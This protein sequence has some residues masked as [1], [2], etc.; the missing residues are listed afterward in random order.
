VKPKDFEQAVLELAMTT[1]VPLTRA[2]IVF[3]SGV[4]AKQTD[5]WLDEMVGNGLLEFDSDDAG[6]MIYKVCGAQRPAGG[7]T[8]LSRCS[9]CQKATGAGS[10]C[11]RCGKLLDPQLRALKDEVDRA[12]SA[13]TVFRQGSNLLSQ[14][15][16]V[17]DK[18][19]VIGGLLGLLG[20]VG[21][22]YAAPMKEAAIGS[23]LF[24]LA[25][26]LLPAILLYPAMGLLTP[27]FVLLGA[28]YA[29]RYNRSGQR[30]SLFL[31]EGET[32]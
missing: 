11:T 29:Y 32:G 1:R 21:W 5:K 16:Q 13:L 27:L 18:N 15:G 31:D 2:N 26:K 14:S 20:P 4:G 9:A 25:Y 8:Q 22:F 17:G 30:T 28:M 24:I 7:A 10:R 12:G 19:L 6:E 23:L 3:Y